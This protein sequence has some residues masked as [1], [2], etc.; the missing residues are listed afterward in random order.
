MLASL[1]GF[2]LVFA[3]VAA[4]PSLRAKIS[5][6]AEDDDW[7]IHVTI[8]ALQDTTFL[9]RGTPFDTVFQCKAFSVYDMD[10]EV[11]LRYAGP[12]ARRTAPTSFDY[13][14]LNAG[15]ELSAVVDLSHCFEFNANGNYVVTLDTTNAAMEQKSRMHFSVQKT[16][17]PPHL[18]SLAEKAASF[19]GCSADQQSTTESAIA[20]AITAVDSAFEDNLMKGCVNSDFTGL[21]GTYSAE[22]YHAVTSTFANVQASFYAENY[23]IKCDTNDCA[24]DDSTYAFVYPFDLHRHVNLCGA[25]WPASTTIQIDSQPGTLIH[26][27]THFADIS[28]TDDFQYGFEECLE[29]GATS[30]CTAVKNADSNCYYAEQEPMFNNA[31]CCYGF[32]ETQCANTANCAYCDGECQE[33]GMCAT[34]IEAGD[35]ASGEGAVYFWSQSTEWCTENQEWTDANGDGCQQYWLFNLCAEYGD[36]NENDG[37]TANEVCC[38]CGGGGGTG[39]TYYELSGSSHLQPTLVGLAMLLVSFFSSL[40][41]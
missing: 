34:A 30:P 29:L 20:N 37:Q 39:W 22:R 35:C 24:D 12:L 32:S 9:R 18:K 38:V 21:F 10:D 15:E 3:A 13:H 1:V 2:C 28:A 31:T 40:L 27:L 19:S 6:V 4:P 8:T 11:P 41:F 17:I 25:F 5:P 36:L 14:S 23:V 33:E 7:T 26:E 16:S